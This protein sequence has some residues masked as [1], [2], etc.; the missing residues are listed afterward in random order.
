MVPVDCCCIQ[1]AYNVEHVSRFAC[2]FY[3]KCSSWFLLRIYETETEQVYC[4]GVL[5]LVPNIFYLNEIMSEQSKRFIVHH[6]QDCITYLLY[7]EIKRLLHTHF[8]ISWNIITYALFSTRCATPR[9]VS[10]AVAYWGTPQVTESPLRSQ[11]ST[12]LPMFEFASSPASHNEHFILD[13]KRNFHLYAIQI[14]ILLSKHS[15]MT[16]KLLHICKNNKKQF[17]LHI[18]N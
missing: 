18:E 9:C 15:H 2:M 3:A 1:S 10:F 13:E 4:S 12:R 5:L 6:P 7:R 16:I 8:N 14:L 11:L 17:F